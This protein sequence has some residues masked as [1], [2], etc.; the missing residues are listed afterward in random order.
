ML[1]KYEKKKMIRRR[2]NYV[3]LCCKRYLQ[4][5]IIIYELIIKAI[6]SPYVYQ[7]NKYI[8]LSIKLGLLWK[9]SEIL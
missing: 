3:L 4:C 5:K 9:D 8:G 2:N 1:T 6:S 7:S